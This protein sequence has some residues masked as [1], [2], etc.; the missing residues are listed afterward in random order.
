MPYTM[1][2]PYKVDSCVWNIK[3]LDAIDFVSGH[4]AGVATTCVYKMLNVIF[5]HPTFIN[6]SKYAMHAMYNFTL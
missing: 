1:L 5:F 2:L 3:K 4:I 6:E